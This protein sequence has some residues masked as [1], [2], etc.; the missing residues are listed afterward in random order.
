MYRVEEQSTYGERAGAGLDMADRL[1]QGTSERLPC[2]VF[3]CRYGLEIA[4]ALDRIILALDSCST[5]SEGRRRWGE[6]KRRRICGGGEEQGLGCSRA[7]FCTAPDS[8]V[9]TASC[10]N[11][12]Q[13]QAVQRR[14][15]F[16]NRRTSNAISR[17]FI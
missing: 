15:R 4:L 3:G 1:N 10:C 12:I 11:A 2:E 17:P 9:W 5:S 14:Y 6:A 8:L 16:P 13:G 7:S